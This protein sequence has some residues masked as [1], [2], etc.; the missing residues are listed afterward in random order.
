MKQ[1][2][3]DGQLLRVTSEGNICGRERYWFPRLQPFSLRWLDTSS[4]GT[5]RT[6]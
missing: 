6:G 2:I 4:D 1:E 3:E 5:S